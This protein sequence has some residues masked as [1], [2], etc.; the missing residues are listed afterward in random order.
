MALAF[1]TA[2]RR[3]VSGNP[4]NTLSFN[5][6]A[7]SN[8]IL[9]L[10]VYHLADTVSATYASVAMTNVFTS[11]TNT[12][13]DRLSGFILVGPAT[14]ANDVVV[15]GDT[16]AD[17]TIQR[18]TIASYNGA[19]QSSQ[20]D[21]FN[22]LK[23]TQSG[24]ITVSITT[25]ATG[26]WITFSELASA[27]DPT[28]VTNGVERGGTLAV[29][30]LADSNGTVSPGSNSVGFTYAAGSQTTTLAAISIAPTVVANTN[31]F[32]FMPN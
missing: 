16:G 12:G 1:N 4:S 31:F 9:V 7:G 6:T 5:N 8:Q 28:G 21:A 13:T 20:P 32:M 17:K 26:A 23:S 2:G 30:C 27:L 10:Y 14:G 19:A 24:D 3:N 25:V 29:A 18:F 22:T 15:T 11:A